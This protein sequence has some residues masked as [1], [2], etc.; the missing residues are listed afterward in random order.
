MSALKKDR[1]DIV[2]EC[3]AESFKTQFLRYVNEVLFEM[4]KPY[5]KDT[6]LGRT[7]PTALQNEVST[8][9]KFYYDRDNRVMFN[10][11][12]NE[13]YT[14]FPFKIDSHPQGVSFPSDIFETFFNNLS[15]DVRYLLISEGDQVPR[16][17]ANFKQSTRK[18]ESPF[19]HKC[20]SES[21]KE[22]HNNKSVCAT[23]NRNPPS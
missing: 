2:S 17:A 10:R 14:R 13:V 19:G 11:S 7:N 20:H 15:P 6:Y 4:V 3:C 23:R 21:R 18:P 1:G 5:L 9:R 12:V 22:G 8:F 16:K